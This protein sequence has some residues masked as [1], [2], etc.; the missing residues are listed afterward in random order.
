MIVLFRRVVP[1]AKS[2]VLLRGTVEISLSSTTKMIESEYHCLWD[3]L[4]F[5]L[6]VLRI[7]IVS[8]SNENFVIVT[9]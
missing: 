3:S 8:K 6:V 4:I 2:T 1:N 9:F 5:V 7:V